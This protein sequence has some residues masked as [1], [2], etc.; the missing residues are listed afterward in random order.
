MSFEWQSAFKAN[1]DSF[2]DDK[3]TVKS[4]TIYT[5]ENVKKN[6]KIH[7][8]RLSPKFK[9]FADKVRIDYGVGGW[10]NINIQ[11]IAAMFVTNG[12]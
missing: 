1:R 4:S 2:E 6:W 7:T 12:P 11:Y 3:S 5:C 10:Q 8:R 9:G